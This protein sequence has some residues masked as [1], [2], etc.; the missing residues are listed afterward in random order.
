MTQNKF[1]L[2]VTYRF[3]SCCG[4]YLCGSFC[5]AVGGYHGSGPYHAQRTRSRR[6]QLIWNLMACQ[7]D[8]VP[9]EPE[10]TRSLREA[11]CAEAELR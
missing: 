6:G 2:L 3:F 1:S 11:N 4:Y 10:P 9:E 5:R 8:P 7:M